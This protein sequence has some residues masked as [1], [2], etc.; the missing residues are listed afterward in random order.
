[1]QTIRTTCPY[2]GVGCGVLAERQ[3]PDGEWSVRG[4]PD[5]PANYGRLCSKGAALAETVELPQRL[6]KPTLRDADGHLESTNWE[7]ALDRVASGFREAIAEH[8]PE[9]VAFYVSG[10]L[11]TED[12]YLANKLMKG[13]LGAANIDTNSRLCMS[14][15]VAAYNRA[16]GSD[17][18]PVSYEDLERADLVVLIGSNTAWAHPVVFQ[19]LMAAKEARPGMRFVVIDPRRTATCDIADLHL[20]VAPGTDILLLNGLLAHLAERGKIDTGFVEAHVEGFESTLAAARAEGTDLDNIAQRCG[21]PVEDIQRFYDWFATTQHSVSL[22]SQGLNQSASGTDKGNAVIN[23]HLA[24]GRIGRPGMGPFSITGQP[25]AMGGREVGGLA[26]QLAAHQGFAEADIDRVRRFWQAPNL[27]TRPGL[28]AVDLFEAMRDGRIKAVWIMATNPAFSLPDSDTVRE[29]LEA[30]PLVVLSECHAGTDTAAFADVLLPAS[31]WGERDGTV[32]NSER[33]ISRQ[34]PFIDAPGQA[35]P[36]W[37]I[38]GQVARRI[39]PDWAPAFDFPDSASVFREYA[40]QTA[41]ENAGSRDLDLS[42]LAGISRQEYDALSP[43][44]WPVTGTTARETTTDG[45][46]AT[47]LFADGRFFTADA[48]ARMIP[49]TNRGAASAL[50]PAFPLRLNTGRLRDQWH[51][52][53]RTGAVPRLNAH[54]SE[55][56][57]SVHPF[58]AARYRLRGGQIARIGNARGEILARVTLDDEQRPGSLFVPMH[59]SRL[60]ASRSGVNTVIAPDT[61]PVSGQPEFKTQAVWAEPYAAQWYG[62]ALIRDDDT[63]AGADEDWPGDYRVVIAG[64][65]HHRFE[66]AGID[67][68]ADWT[69]W[70]KSRLAPKADVARQWIEFADPK[71]GQYR[72]ACL[73]EGRLQA[74]LFVSASSRRPDVGWLT[75]LFSRESLSDSDQADLLAG[76]PADS[77]ED[78]GPIVCACFDVGRNTLIDAIDTHRITDARALGDCTQAGTNCGSCIP[79]LK[80]LIARRLTETSH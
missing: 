71:G 52:M 30:C 60:T 61:D 38:I 46:A 48:R 17:T 8:G 49:V 13:Y 15:A 64:D 67:A 36:D 57:A 16:F 54:R 55:P 53:T 32:T 9:S 4:D 24:T 7:T 21:L 70:A 2:C 31:T 22:W 43:T 80:Q 27:A 19:R 68:P 3:A 34:R 12:Y 14:S 72:I 25:N 33:C 79:E 56:A 40:R 58:D 35:R 11:L 37:W 10:Q 78:R 29:A 45:A 1:M 28:K 44:R 66:L 73:T 63:P 39:D 26:N 5:H 75:D 59:W 47:E 62:C 69:A 74:V 77:G 18:V 41:F 76:K 50:T 6:L 42:G 23:L 20:P 65:G 51:G